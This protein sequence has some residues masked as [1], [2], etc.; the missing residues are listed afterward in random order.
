M[1]VGKKTGGRNFEKGDNRQR[2]PK[3]DP[4]F[5][6][7]AQWTKTE[8]EAKMHNMLQ[9]SVLDLRNIIA[10]ESNKVIDHWIARIILMGIKGG[11]TTRLNFMFEQIYGKLPEI[12]DVN[13]KTS[14]SDILDV[15]ENL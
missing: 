4:D 15:I 10:L 3:K 11:D 7:L 8:I 6:A 1:A 12:K 2:R 13:I 5:K 9:Y 14:H